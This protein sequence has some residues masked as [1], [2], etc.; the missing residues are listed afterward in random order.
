MTIYFLRHAEAEDHAASDFDRKLTPKGLQQA[1]KVG[2]FCAAHGLVPV[3]I[4]SSPVTR[5]RQTAELVASALGMEVALA[6]WLACGMETST[7]LERLAPHAGSDSV[8]V[9]GHEPDFSTAIGDLCGS[10]EPG[11]IV[12]TKA[13]LTAVD[14]P[15]LEPGAGQLQF[16]IPCRLM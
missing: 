10:T 1:E 11:A 2:K 14:A 12:V 15:W 5:A 7:L 9:V 13:S 3:A 4:L 8:L 6:D 16:S